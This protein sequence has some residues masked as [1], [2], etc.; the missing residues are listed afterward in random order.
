MRQLIGALHLRRPILLGHS[1]GGTVAAFVAA[2]VD[3]A[4][5]ILLE[6]MIGDRAFTEN[7]AVQA[8]PLA[9][10]LGRPVAGFDAYLSMWRARREPYS[11]DAERLVDRWARFALA[12]LPGGGYRER[13]LRAAVEAEWASIIG[14]DSLGALAR[15]RCPVLIVRAMKPWF[16]GRPYFTSRI[17]DAQLRAAPHATLFTAR[18]SD[19]AGILR[20]PEPGMMDALRRFLGSCLGDRESGDLR[21]RRRRPAP[22]RADASTRAPRGSSARGPTR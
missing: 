9:E 15:V 4:G 2:E 6:A 22:V 14:A 20:D 21:S 5:L 17:V 19:H 12:P 18:Q 7:A 10:S 11:D 16:G 13:A 3:V 1:A 8:S